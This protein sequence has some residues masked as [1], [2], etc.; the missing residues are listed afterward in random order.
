MNIKPH[1]IMGP[2]LKRDILYLP[3]HIE[4]SNYQ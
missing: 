3:T 2:M 1:A 4:N